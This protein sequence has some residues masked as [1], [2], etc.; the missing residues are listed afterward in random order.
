MFV[1]VH[2]SLATSRACSVVT[3]R[4]QLN[5]LSPLTSQIPTS[6]WKVGP[7]LWLLFRTVVNVIQ[8]IKQGKPEVLPLKL[9]RV[10]CWA[11]FR[12]TSLIWH[13]NIMH[14]TANLCHTLKD[15]CWQIYKHLSF[16]SCACIH[17]ALDLAFSS[18]YRDEVHLVESE[19]CSVIAAASMLQLVSRHTPLHSHQVHVYIEPSLPSHY[20]SGLTV[21][22]VCDVKTFWFIIHILH[23]TRGHDIH[24]STAE[25]CAMTSS[26]KF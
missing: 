22:P 10:N 4:N 7:V 16:M 15:L 12:K 18:L 26:R 23:K 17:A 21:A 19:I 2:S 3:G 8:G 13:T 9:A 20:S 24:V 25:N 6:P 11:L 14:F 1:Y 5:P